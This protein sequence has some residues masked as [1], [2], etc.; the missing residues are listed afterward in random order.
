MDL[1]I[2][3]YFVRPEIILSFSGLVLLLVAA[4]SKNATRL[5][6]IASVAALFAA[7]AWVVGEFMLNPSFELGGDAF[8]GLYR[9]DALGSYSKLLIYFAAAISLIIA[10]RYLEKAGAMRGEFP[11]LVLFAVIGMSIM[12][13][14]NDLITLI[15]AW[16]LTVSPPMCWPV[17]CARMSGR[18]KQA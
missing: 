8:D 9:M 18:Q 6:S 14:A 1:G 3:L 12:V 16:N 10:P 11:I 5:I 17:S 13:S 7:A 4:W 2:S 15:S